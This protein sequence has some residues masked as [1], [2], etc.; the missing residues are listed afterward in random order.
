M[1]NDEG[2]LRGYIE[3]LLADPELADKMGQ[4]AR[5][6][7]KEKFSEERFVNEWNTIFNKV[8]GEGR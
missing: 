4:A 5:E 6:T 1:S 3:K 7:I 8:Y 2:E